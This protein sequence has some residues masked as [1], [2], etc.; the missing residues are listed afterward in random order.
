MSTEMSPAL[1]LTFCFILNILGCLENLTIIFPIFLTHSKRF[2]E[3]VADL[4]QVLKALDILWFSQTVLTFS[5]INVILQ[6]PYQCLF[7]KY[8][9]QVFQKGLVTALRFNL[10]KYSLAFIIYF[11]H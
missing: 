7:G 5:T 4:K 3:S 8:S 9:L 10:S 1:A 6:P 2:S 11:Y